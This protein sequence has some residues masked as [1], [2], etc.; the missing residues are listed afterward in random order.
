[1]RTYL[2]CV[3]CG[4]VGV[5]ATRL[6]KRKSYDL[7]IIV[8]GASGRV[9]NLLV[10][11]L[12]VRGHSL[13]LVSRQP[14][15]LVDRGPRCVNVSVSEWENHAPGVDLFLNLAAA[16][17]DS[18]L[19]LQ[20]FLQA[21]R[22]FAVD[23]AK[24]CDELGIPK[25]IY[26]STVHALDLSRASPYAESKRQGSI[27][28]RAELGDRMQTLY[29][30]TVY[31]STFLGRMR[32]LNHFQGPLRKIAFLLSSAAKPVTSSAS[33]VSY[34]DSLATEAMEQEKILVDSKEKNWFYRAWRN[35]LHSAFLVLFLAASPLLAAAALAVLVVDGRPVLFLQARIG[36]DGNLFTCPK[37]R[38]MKRGTASTGTHLADKA[39]VTV[40]GKL[41]R[42][43]KVDELPQVFSVVRGEMNLIGPRPC[44]PSQRKLVQLRENYGIIRERPGITGWAQANGVD[45][46]NPHKLVS[47]E[48]A[49]LANQSVSF[50]LK[51]LLTTVFVRMRADRAL[52][53]GE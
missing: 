27:A 52:E 46:S 44:L 51:I 3:I 48:K 29:L 8:S 40:T 37:L 39:A 10:T 35:L 9:A 16:N 11:D 50:D 53:P 36:R 24:R 4:T 31:G 42:S 43:T 41:M 1:M 13:I 14:E 25:F 17:N 7:K 23:L 19:P 33:I 34:I 5:F 22:D 32:L 21:N 45:M 26:V 49:Y 6:S 28:V 15:L 2:C 20:D 30:G 18:G 47:Y 12:L 38:T